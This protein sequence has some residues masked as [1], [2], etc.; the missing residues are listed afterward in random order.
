MNK[1]SVFYKNI[2][3]GILEKTGDENFIF[4]Y[5]EEY[6]NSNNPSISLTLPK[7][8]KRFESDSLFPFF[9]GLIPEGWLLNLASTELRL[10]PLRDRFELLTRLCHDTIGAVHIGEKKIEKKAAKENALIVSLKE[11]KVKKYGKCC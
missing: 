4:I 8:E 3:A 10:N 1:V 7:A 11:V 9:D 5:D 2:K 6:L